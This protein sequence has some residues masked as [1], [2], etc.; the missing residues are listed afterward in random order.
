[1]IRKTSRILCLIALVS[2]VTLLAQHPTPAP[3]HKKVPEVDYGAGPKSPSIDNYYL[4][5]DPS[6]FIPDEFMSNPG[7][8][9]DP[10]KLKGYHLPP[11]LKWVKI[12]GKRTIQAGE[13]IKLEAQAEAPVAIQQWQLYYQ[14][15]HGRASALRANF[16]PRKDNPWL[17][18]GVVKTSKWAEPGIYIVYDGELNTELGHSKAYFAP[19]H[20]AIHGLEF[21]VLPNPNMDLTPPELVGIWIGDTETADNGKT[22]DVKDVI[23]VRM[24]AKDNLSGVKDVTLRISG[25]D[26]KY[27]EVKLQPFFARPGEFIGSF[28]INPFNVGGEYI[29]RTLSIVDEAG[30]RKEI[31]AP[32]NKL[33]QAVK[34]NITQD[35]KR[36]DKVAPRLISVAFD[37]MTAKMG[38]EIKISAIAVDDNAGVGDVFVDV[39][40]SPS[41]I[42]KKRVRLSAKARPV[43][44]KPGF[45]IQD[46]VFE[47][48]F[49]THLL[50]EPGDWIV[51]RVFVRD[52]ANNY[53]DVRATE[54]GDLAAVKVVLGESGSVAPSTSPSAA[55]G[56]PAGPPKI[57]RV[58]MTPPHPPR[59][60]C[61]NCHEPSK[62]KL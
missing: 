40:A 44:I 60:P 26:N 33:L 53:T 37:K 5:G 49:K 46:N 30:N 21:E 31:F 39:A 47:G 48:S 51:T 2:A 10:T 7:D 56:A 32:T 41:F 4:E 28:R 15:P 34:F 42:D 18:D 59:G 54:N 23:P 35:P 3:D 62:E 11:I 43:L 9:V 14:G 27:V 20:P 36:V 29:A 24:K 22:F 25:P 1:M 12:V 55:T 50:D 38:D 58:D 52:N 13:D 45:D 61:L 19:M 6:T 16:T 57:R 17:H 8:E